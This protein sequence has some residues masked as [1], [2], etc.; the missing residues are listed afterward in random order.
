MRRTVSRSWLAG[1]R[2]PTL[3]LA[4]LQIPGRHRRRL[5]ASSSRV[6]VTACRIPVSS[7]Q[8]RRDGSHP[9]GLPKGGPATRHSNPP[10]RWIRLP[11]APP[12]GL[13]PL[14]WPTFRG[15]AAS[16]P[17]VSRPLYLPRLACTRGAPLQGIE[18]IEEP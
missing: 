18:G 17:P 9:L 14:A 2:A 4:S 15:P 12:G 7:R 10:S 1:R 8:D 6:H 3:R 5:S 16:F 11:V 13:T